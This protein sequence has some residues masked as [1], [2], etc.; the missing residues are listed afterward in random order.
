MTEKVP[1]IIKE[2]VIRFERNISSHKS[3]GY[4]EAQLR[5][6]FINPF[7]EALGWHVYNKGGAAP[8][9]RDVIH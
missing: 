2:L 3:Q 8:A 4:N 9:Y 5:Q 6:E 7:F 1:E